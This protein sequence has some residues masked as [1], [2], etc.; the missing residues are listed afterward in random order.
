[1][2]L[3]GADLHYSAAANFVCSV[4]AG[5]YCSHAGAVDLHCAAAADLHC[6][7][8]ATLFE[9]F[10]RALFGR[11]TARA[12]FLFYIHALSLLGSFL[13]HPILRTFLFARQGFD[14]LHCFLCVEHVDSI[15][16]GRR[17][18]RGRYMLL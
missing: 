3:A 4:G 17:S 11:T 13:F 12:V 14:G 8:G 1:M 10:G 16:I 18:K 15:S 7:I 6:A 2:E 9:A 5:L